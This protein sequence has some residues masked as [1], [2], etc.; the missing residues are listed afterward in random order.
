MDRRQETVERQLKRAD[1]MSGSAEREV[2]PIA[3]LLLPAMRAV[4]TA[5]LRLERDL[6]AL[7]LIEALR[8]YAAEHAGSLPAALDEITEVPVPTNPATGKPFQYRLDGQTA[9]LDLPSSEGF[10]GYNRRFEI[11]VAVEE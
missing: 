9:I 1:L 6:A 8:M 4:R 11:K 10:P 7:R 5:Q 2:L 3:P